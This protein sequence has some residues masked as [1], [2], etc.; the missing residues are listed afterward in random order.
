MS[1]WIRI[2]DEDLVECFKC[3]CCDGIM[4]VEFPFCPYCGEKMEEEEENEQ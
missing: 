3:S 4:P 2:F 1:K